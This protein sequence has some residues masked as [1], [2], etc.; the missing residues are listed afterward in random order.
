MRRG[1]ATAALAGVAA[2]SGLLMAAA[3]RPPAASSQAA[4]A[5]ADP[6]TVA[7]GRYLAAA[8]DCQGCHTNP[9][10]AP[11]AGGRVVPTPFGTILSANLTPDRTGIG[12]WT[13]DQFYRALHTGVDDEGKHLYPAFPYNYYTL[14]NRGDSDA[15]FAY[16]KTV[17][18]V[19]NSPRRDQLPFPLNIRFFVRFWNLMFLHQGPMRANPA[20]SAEW[21][22]GAYLVEA[23][24]H[25]QACHTPKTMLGG[26]KRDQA[27]RG[28]AFGTWFAPDLTP[29][30]RTGLGGWS[31]AELIEFLKTGRNAHASAS[32]E[33]GDV[34]RYSTS[35]L[36]DADLGAIA[37]YVTDQPASSPRQATAPD[38]AVMRQ[39]QAIFVDSCSACHRMDGRGVPGLF[40]P[41]VGDANLQQADPT[42]TLH[43]IVGGVQA[44]PTDARPTALSMPSYGWKLTDDQVA[45]VATYVRN[46]WGNAAPA[47]SAHQAGKLRKS[48]TF[49]PGPVG[50]ERHAPLSHPGPTT[51]TTAGT[52]S[53]DN[54]TANAGRAAPAS[55][56]SGGG[57]SGA[58]NGGSSKGHPAGV[59]AGGPG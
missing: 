36:T 46:S 34:V 43:F 19:R 53:R 27:F 54:G 56:G 10:G 47:V 59:N 55:A 2:A 48:V 22:R 18:P 12:D 40:P 15:I 5:P 4:A 8:G 45:A 29:N 23:L 49:G 51:W 14:L 58:E 32:G 21:N 16:L 52:D 41:L 35:Q 28:G 30:R 13:A 17:Q 38:P 20:K 39:G 31:R 1:L 57:R 25:C 26:P 44:T 33:M 3:V 9:G 42:T 24:G 6:A 50:T 11:F 7:R 37:T